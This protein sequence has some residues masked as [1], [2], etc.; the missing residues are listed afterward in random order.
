MICGSPAT[1]VEA[2]TE[3]D[4]IGVGGLLMVFRIGPMPAE[5]A[6]ASIRLFMEKVAPEFHRA[7]AA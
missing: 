2:I 3:I 7:G 4:R 5:V 1:V 6:Q